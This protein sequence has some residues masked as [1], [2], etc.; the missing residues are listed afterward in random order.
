[1]TLHVNTETIRHVS[2]GCSKLAQKQYKNIVKTQNEKV[3][4]Y[5]ELAFEVKRIHQASKV[6][7]ITTV[8]G[9]LGTISKDTRT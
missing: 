9:A 5:Q 6:S 4:S 3:D 2:R 1:M 7:V 8:V